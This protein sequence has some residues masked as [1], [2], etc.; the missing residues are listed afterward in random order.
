MHKRLVLI[1]SGILLSGLLAGC[2]VS[3]KQIEKMDNQLKSLG[4][5]GV[6]DS[7]LSSIKVHTY[8]A[9][10]Q[11][12][13]G[14]NREANSAAD[15]AT[16]LL[17]LA[18]TMLQKKSA[19]IK[20]IVTAILDSLTAASPTLTGLMQHQLDSAKAVVDSF[21]KLDRVYQAEGCAQQAMVLLASLRRCEATAADMQTKIPGV[22]VCTNKL[23][24]ETYAEV[25][26]LEKKTFDFK[27]D[28]AVT[29]TETS[30]GQS[31]KDLK[32][33][34]EFISIGTYTLLG[35]TVIMNINRFRRVKEVAQQLDIIDGKKGWKKTVVPPCD[36]TIT[37]G[38]QD[39]YTTY[40]ELTEDWEQTKK[41]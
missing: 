30:S 15:S 11:K 19:E 38:S 27:K 31:A 13:L 17:G 35:D 14:M 26:G 7:M 37:D 2:G 39:R 41:Y 20:P 16:A 32:M 36:S 12:R 22:W 23:T 40:S 18:E 6:P 33:D 10:E 24:S 34:Y 8:Q 1:V 5:R 3:D 28:G 29:L 25:K 21:V 9:R 4:D